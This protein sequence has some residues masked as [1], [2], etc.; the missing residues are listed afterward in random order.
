MSAGTLSAPFGRPAGL[1][2][3]HILV[4]RSRR[5]LR[6][7]LRLDYG[8][9]GNFVGASKGVMFSL[10]PLLVTNDENGA[11]HNLQLSRELRSVHRSEFFLMNTDKPIESPEEWDPNGHTGQYDTLARAIVLSF[12]DYKYDTEDM[13]AAGLEPSAAGTHL[14]ARM[15]TTVLL[16]AALC[17]A[18]AKHNPYLHDAPQAVEKV[19]RRTHVRKMGPSS[20]R[21]Y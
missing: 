14:E 6:C 19:R 3:C 2:P 4:D 11:C 13:K 20:F 1:P 9:N 7:S 17:E 12:R 8:L 21:S 5:P 10:P 15:I 16:T 18:L